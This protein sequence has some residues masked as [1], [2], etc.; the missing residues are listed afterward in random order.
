MA[1]EFDEILSYKPELDL[2]KLGT[3]MLL[4]LAQPPPPPRPAPPPPSIAS[5]TS[6]PLP[7]P[8]DVR[9]L[10]GVGVLDLAIR[11]V[12]SCLRRKLIVGVR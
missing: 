3:S 6:L 7:G 9:V 8:T 12:I 11:L 10:L 2:E 4:I 5:P 1:V